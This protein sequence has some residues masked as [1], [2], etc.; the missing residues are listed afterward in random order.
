MAL[1]AWR[2]RAASLTTSPG[3]AAPASDRDTSAP[4]GVAD[5]TRLASWVGPAI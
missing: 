3:G 4:G 1:S 2:A 5:R